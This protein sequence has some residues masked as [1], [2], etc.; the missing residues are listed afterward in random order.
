M[1]RVTAAEASTFLRSRGH[2]PTNVLPLTGGEWSAAFAFREGP[3][4]YVIR[5]HERRDD[6]EKDR[7]AQRWVSD[8]LRTPRILE[9]GDLEQGA[10]GISERVRGTPLDDLDEAGMRRALPPLFAAMDALREADLGEARGYWGWHGDGNA[11]AASWRDTLLLR[12]P[13]RDVMGEWR[14]IAAG[15][16]LGTAE[17]DAGV[18][19]IRELLP[20]CPEER[21]VVH[22]DLLNYNVL[23]DDA[24]VVLLDWGAAWYGDFLYDVALLAFWWPRYARWPGIDIRREVE[25]H[26]AAIGLRVP[27]FA[28]RLACYQVHIGVEHMAYQVGRGRLEDARWTARHTVEVANAP[29]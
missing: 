1:K 3:R 12:Q 19:R 2:D 23:V 17:F 11:E 4:E 29:L 15:S 13:R 9:I 6:L 16:P 21:S 25:R 20:F 14:A 24:D 5:F 27:A 18:A 26:Y 22:N 28:E 10:Y 8:R 7:Y